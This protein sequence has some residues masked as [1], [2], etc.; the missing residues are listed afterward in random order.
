M[1][2]SWTVE[3]LRPEAVVCLM[4]SYTQRQAMERLRR[5]KKVKEEVWR[6]EEEEDRLLLAG[7]SC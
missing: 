5:T 1:E 2:V 4:I 6:N 7:L 3:D